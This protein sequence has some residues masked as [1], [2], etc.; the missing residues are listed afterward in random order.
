MATEHSVFTWD[1]MGARWVHER[2]PQMTPP[3]NPYDVHAL[4]S[5]FFDPDGK[6]WI[7]TVLAPRGRELAAQWRGAHK[8]PDQAVAAGPAQKKSGGTVPILVAGLAILVLG[9]GAVVVA[10]TQLAPTAATAT[11]APNTNATAA[12]GQTLAATSAQPAASATPAAPA[13]T[14]PTQAPVVTAPPRTLAPVAVNLP[15]GPRVTMPDGVTIVYT[16]ATTATRGGFLQTF[17]TGAQANGRPPVGELT[18]ILGDITKDPRLL[19]GQFDANGK[20]A[21]DMPATLAVGQYPLSVSWKGSRLQ[22]ATI[23]IR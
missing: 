20:I 9:G 13:T 6:E 15:A 11:V 10:G 4:Q 16:G 7:A 3:P 21:L 8:I 23:T 19:A 2:G 17:F 18:I 1:P 5:Y 22:I 14:A 12:P